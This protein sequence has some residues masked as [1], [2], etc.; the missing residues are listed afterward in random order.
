MA[1][2]LEQEQAK[3]IQHYGEIVAALGSPPEQSSGYTGTND[4]LD[5]EGRLCHTTGLGNRYI[6]A[7]ELGLGEEFKSPLGNVNK[8]QVCVVRPWYSPQERTT[9]ERLKPKAYVV[10]RVD[11]QKIVT[12]PGESQSSEQVVR[13]NFVLGE[14]GANRTFD[15]WVYQARS[16]GG[17][18]N[19]TTAEK[20][21]AGL[22][23]KFWES[24]AQ[25]VVAQP[26][27]VQ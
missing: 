6:S 5:S 24:V 19:T 4:F 16:P 13:R 7:E 23:A 8:V 1:V 21:V 20:V 17:M 15:S 18:A 9:A 27:A 3:L 2:A 22:P 10:A 12:N 26:A 25:K 11:M 14:D